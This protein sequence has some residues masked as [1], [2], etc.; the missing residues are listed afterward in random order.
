[1]E[2]A[3]RVDFKSYKNAAK[4]A[5][6]INAGYSANL[7]GIGDCPYVDGDDL[8]NRE[9]AWIYGHQMAQRHVRGEVR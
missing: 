5:V 8:A 9:A 6:E 3:V 1:M 2:K 7:F 4:Y